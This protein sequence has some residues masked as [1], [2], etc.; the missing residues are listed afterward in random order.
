MSR[1][2][3]TP[4]HFPRMKVRGRRNKA[5]LHLRITQVFEARARI[6]HADRYGATL[7]VDHNGT[8]IIRQSTTRDG[9]GRTVKEKTP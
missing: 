2:P 5:K 6:E 3:R 7:V 8:H 1:T 4:V 9:Y